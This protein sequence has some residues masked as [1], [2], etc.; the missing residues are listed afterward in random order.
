MKKGILILLVGLL[1]CNTSFAIIEDLDIPIKKAEAE[2]EIIKLNN[3]YMQ[4]CELDLTIEGE[5]MYMKVISKIN[6]I[7]KNEFLVNE[8]IMD[9][10]ESGIL[11]MTTTEKIATD[12]KV[13]KT[14]IKYDYTP[15]S[16]YNLK[17]ELKP[18][19]KLLSDFSNS[20]KFTNDL[21][22]NRLSPGKKLDKESGKE[23]MRLLKKNIKSM[24]PDEN[25]KEMKKFFKEI[26]MNFYTE[27]L[28]TVEINGEKFYVIKE[29]LV[30]EHSSNN[31]ELEKEMNEENVPTFRFIHAASGYSSG[32][33][34]QGDSGVDSYD[35]TC[36]IYKDNQE[37][38]EVD[39]SEYL[40]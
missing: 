30:I 32:L 19:K 26:T 40:N 11:N 17:K 33:Y 1:W 12:G 2:T 15:G 4:T 35:M 14:K 37:L 28:G 10:Q 36:T 3:R 39:I 25:P 5:Y 31:L 34:I 29:Q 22:G 23:A 16:E 21:Y 20:S 7:N 38:L 24:F 8:I 9:L 13:S 27:Y 18:L 6:K